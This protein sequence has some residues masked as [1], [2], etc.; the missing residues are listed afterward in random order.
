MKNYHSKLTTHINISSSREVFV[1]IRHMHRPQ[2]AVHASPPAE[3]I[4][5]RMIVSNLG[6]KNSEQCGRA[7]TAFVCQLVYTGQD[8]LSM[9]LEINE[10]QGNR[11]LS[12]HSED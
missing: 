8:I 5:D 6:G 12:R 7:I 9:D 10:C 1:V 3:A 11:W 4:L 2:P